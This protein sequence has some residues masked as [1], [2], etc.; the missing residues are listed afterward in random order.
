M[1]H[2]P[3]AEDAPVQRCAHLEA[4]AEAVVG[5]PLRPAAEHVASRRSRGR[6]GSALQW[7]MGLQP[8]D[9]QAQ[10]DWEDRIEIKL[11]SVWGR[12]LDGRG[13]IA[14]D[15]LKVCDVSIDPWQKLSNV[16]FV[17][18]D[19]L[20]RVVVGAALFRLCGPVREGLAA[21]WGADPHFEHPLLFVEAREQGNKRAPAYYL[22]SRFFAQADLLPVG[23]PG[24]LPFDARWWNERRTEHGRDPLLSIIVPEQAEAACPR[25]SAPLHFES[26]RLEQAGWAPA[27]HGLP[28]GD[29][30]GLAAHAVV[31]SHRLRASPIQSAEEF[32][33]GVE[34]RLA[35]DELWRVADRVIEPEDHLHG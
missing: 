19:R 2:R 25:C 12:G 31:S 20:T 28:L 29:P 4:L 8:H 22:A 9:G 18:A 30:C 7:H 32:R 21:A 27:R 6:H 10:L 24:V 3:P 11:V 33:A 15:K 35:P 23:A 5:V 16:L 34:C 14:C 26:A 17:F 13:G 1:R